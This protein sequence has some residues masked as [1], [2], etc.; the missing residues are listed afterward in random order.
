VARHVLVRLDRVQTYT[1]RQT[2]RASEQLPL[3]AI[4]RLMITVTASTGG[5]NPLSHQVMVT[6]TVH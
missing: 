5:S 6:L 2:R 3:M 1:A 4:S